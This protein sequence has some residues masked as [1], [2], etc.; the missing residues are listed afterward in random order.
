MTGYSGEEILGRNCRKAFRTIRKRLLAGILLPVFLVTGALYPI[1]NTHLEDRVASAQQI[2]R[3]LLDAEYDA[4]VREMNESLNHTLAIAALPS[5]RRLLEAGREARSPYREDLFQRDRTQL[6]GLFETLVT[7][8]GRYTRLTLVDKDGRTQLSAGVRQR[9]PSSSDQSEAEVL[10]NTMDLPDRSVYVSPPYLGS[11]GAGPEVTT[12]LM[13]IAAPVF[14]GKGQRLGVLVFTL[15]WHYLVS[16][17]PHTMKMGAD[18]N[19]LLV[20]ARGAS[21]LPNTQSQFVLGSSLEYQ[22]PTAWNRMKTDA[23]GEAVIDNRILMFRSHD[24]RNHHYRSQ[25]EQVVS[26]AGSQPWQLA[27][28]LP[29]PTIGSL[30]Q[31]NSGQLI[32]VVL[33]YLLASSFGVFWVLSHHRQRTLRRKAQRSSLQAQQYAQDLEDLYEQAPCGYHSLDAQGRVLKMNDTELEW[34]GYQAD[35]VVGKRHYRDFVT[36]ETREAFD[37]AFRDV[38]AEGHEG[39]AECELLCRDGSVLPVAIEATAHINDERFQYSRAIVFDLTERK[40]IEELLVKQSMTDPLTGLGNRR[41]LESQAELEIARSRRSDLPLSLIAIDL[42]HF[43]RINDT[44]G[45]DIGDQV[46]KVFADTAQ[47]QLRDGDILCRIGGEEFTVLLPETTEKQAWIIA[48]RLRQ[49]IESTPA[50]LG[51]GVPEGG[52]LGYSASL[53][54]T[55]VHPEEVS[56]KAAI[57]RA[58]ARLYEAKEAGRNRVMGD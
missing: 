57:K 8:F 50:E 12:T 53:G 36:P 56:L 54:I 9:P 49:A 4:L 38:L 30:L 33:T 3:S 40:Q 5:L 28:T 20:D 47:D 45:H 1:L 6:D 7:H 21:L 48:E 13:D 15:D 17:L 2:A 31:V 10:W 32:I 16:G 46:L 39:S 43:K 27:V 22:W 24:F 35:E 34:L 14:G 23:R 37:A 26:Q 44:Y 52:Q 51:T 18:A 42:D 55:R 58:D 25:A 29:R 19:V 41:Y 11:S